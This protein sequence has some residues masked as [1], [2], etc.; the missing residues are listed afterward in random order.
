MR[1]YQMP[2]TIDW[3]SVQ[4]MVVEFA[5]LLVVVAAV[6]LAVAADRLLARWRIGRVA[7]QLGATVERTRGR[8]FPVL[9]WHDGPRSARL[10]FPRRH[11]GWSMRATVCDVELELPVRLSFTIRRRGILGQAALWFW[12]PTPADELRTGHDVFDRA[13][14]VRGSDL[15]VLRS[16]ITRDVRRSLLRLAGNVAG[17][18]VRFTCDG[19]RVTASLD[20]AVTDRKALRFFAETTV[21]VA[22]AVE[23]AAE[24][25]AVHFES[26]A[27]RDGSTFTL[28]A[29]PACAEPVERVRGRRCS[30]CA[31]PHHDACFDYL[32]GC[33]VWGCAGGAPRHSPS[34]A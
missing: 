9:S 20:G 8:L 34:A 27:G 16:W 19:E 3:A 17:H 21:W 11:G 2:T 32:G 10:A 7:R 13:F 30:V 26:A 1:V 24:L 25:Q 18:T 28:H 6:G 14:V 31:A 33:G 4:V 29:C 22:R 5:P 12:T 23:C 15:E